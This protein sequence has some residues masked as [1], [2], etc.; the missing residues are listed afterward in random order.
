M[1]SLASLD[2]YI[3]VPRGAADV[4]W[5]DATVALVTMFAVAMGISVPLMYLRGRAMRAMTEAERE[6]WL[7]RSLEDSD[8]MAKFVVGSHGV[9]L[10][11][12]ACVVLTFLVIVIVWAFV[13]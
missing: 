1:W 11:C 9:T 5:K 4:F 8:T 10:A 13:R 7:D 2:S 12:G 6:A 3:R